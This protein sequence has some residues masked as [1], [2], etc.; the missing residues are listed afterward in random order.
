M[1]VRRSDSSRF[2]RDLQKEVLRL[3]LS[4]DDK[5]KVKDYVSK[6]IKKFKE[7]KYKYEDIAIPRGL[8]NLPHKYLTTSPWIRGCIYSQNYL[9]LK[10]KIGDK[11]R[12]LYVKQMPPRLP[13]TKELCFFNN[14]EVPKGIEIDWDK[15]ITK[16]VTMKLEHILDAVGWDINDIIGENK[17]LFEF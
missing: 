7:K 1:E 4:D 3:I 8:T 14:H 17:S 13:P 6:E 2:T 11:A 5:I 10:F 16:C 15:M 9:N 12:L